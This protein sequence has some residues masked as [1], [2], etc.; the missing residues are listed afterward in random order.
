MR[1]SEQTEVEKIVLW[2]FVENVLLCIA[3]WRPNVL[4]KELVVLAFVRISVEPE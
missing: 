1:D 4:L 3:Q 2:V